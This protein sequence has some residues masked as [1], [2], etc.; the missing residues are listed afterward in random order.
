MN[1]LLFVA[2][3]AVVSGAVVSGL[4]VVGGPGQARAEKRD[5]QRIAD[6]HRIADAIICD[7]GDGRAF[8]RACRSAA[9]ATDPQ[10]GAAY[11]VT[12]GEDAFQVCARFE[13]AQAESSMRDA[14]HFDGARGCLRYQLAQPSK[15]WV[16]EG[17]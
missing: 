8:S 13:L 3:I 6:L 14:L 5:D 4:A 10:T 12:Q 9:D 15:Q 1:K 11:E 17:H 2:V 7:A 16:I